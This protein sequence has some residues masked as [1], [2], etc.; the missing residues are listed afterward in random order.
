MARARFVALLALLCGPLGA[1]ATDAPHEAGAYCS[2][3]HMGHNAPGAALT[4][5][6]GNANLCNSCHALRSTFGFPWAVGDQGAP[7]SRGRSHRWDAPATNL[8]A[9]AP[10]PASADPVEREMGLRLDGGR[11]QCSTCHDQHQADVF[12]TD[13]TKHVSVALATNLGRLAGSGTGTL[14]LTAVPSGAQ[15]AAY[16]IKVSAA[17]AFKVSHDNGISYFGYNAAATPRWAADSTAGYA[18]GKPFVSGTPVTLD[19]ELT[20]VT[21]TGTF[22]SVAPVDTFAS[23]YVSYPYLRADNALSRMCTTCHRD[24]N[25]TAANVEGTGP[26]AGTGQAIVLGTTV[27]HHPVG[28]ALSKPYDRAAGAILD[29]DGSAQSAGTEGRKTN[30]LVLGAGGVVHCMTCHH[31][32]N[33]DSNSLTDDPR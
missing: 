18:A 27:F 24:R 7:G 22:D 31:P 16:V 32:H 1:A 15:A 21:F 29:A 4:K 28:Q 11:L 5:S 6:Q 26:H 33:A 12:T 13:A 3:C 30:D 10:D 2:N 9:T 25:Q 19:D 20:Q 17:N 23:F 14:Q 8:G